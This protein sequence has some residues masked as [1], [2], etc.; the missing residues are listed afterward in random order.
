AASTEY[1]PGARSSDGKSRRAVAL[2]TSSPATSPSIP[3]FDPKTVAPATVEIP[4][5]NTKSES[6]EDA[7]TSISRRAGAPDAI[8]EVGR[9]AESR[10]RTLARVAAPEPI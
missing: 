3:V 2:P 4:K 7:A 6:G 1:T 8:R 10:R 9:P 5:P